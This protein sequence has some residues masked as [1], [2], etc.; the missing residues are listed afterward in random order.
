MICRAHDARPTTIASALLPT[1]HGL[2]RR[3]GEVGHS[4]ETQAARRQG[5]AIESS[6]ALQP[7]EQPRL[8]VAAGG[9][10]L[11]QTNVF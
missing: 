2:A 5:R 10:A 9:A 4:C 1:G 7:R 11:A 3:A 6:I 8:A